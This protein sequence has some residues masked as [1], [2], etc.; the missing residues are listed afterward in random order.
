MEQRK[1]EGE[2]G[3]STATL[4]GSRAP[5]GRLPTLEGGGG[6]G[7]WEPEGGGGVDMRRLDTDT[8]KLIQPGLDSGSPLHHS[9]AAAR[10]AGLCT[11]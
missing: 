8:G 6:G 11:A 4:A 7:A 9:P 3:V 1:Q 10:E 5:P 2:D